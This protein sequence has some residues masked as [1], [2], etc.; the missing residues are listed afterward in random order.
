[1]N[2]NEENSLATNAKLE[3]ESCCQTLC[4]S[5]VVQEY[6][7]YLEQKIKQLEDTINGCN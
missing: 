7:Q 1:M 4:H 5:S 6:I 3:L 2:I